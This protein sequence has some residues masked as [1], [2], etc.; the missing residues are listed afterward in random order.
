MR[1]LA[2][3][4]L[5][6]PPPA[7]EG[8]WPGIDHAWALPSAG[9]WFEW[10]TG[11]RLLTDSLLGDADELLAARR[12]AVAE[13]R[14]EADWAKRRAD[15]RGKFAQIFGRSS[16]QGAA[17]RAQHSPLNPK[18]TKRT[19]HPELNATVE[20]L[21]FESRPGFFVT[22]GLWLPAEDAPGKDP[23]TGKR[24]GILFAS[25]HSCQAWRRLDE[26]DYFDYHFLLLQLVRKGFV[27]L[28]YDPPGQGERLFYLN[29]TCP[30]EGPRSACNRR[31]L[32]GGCAWDINT[33]MDLPWG[34]SSTNEHSYL[35][36][37][38][39]LNNVTAA[40]IW[41]W[42]GTRALDL[43]MSRPE[44][45]KERVGM[46][47]CSGGGTQTAYLSSVDERIQAASVA[48]YSSAFEVDFA[49]GGSGADAE[50][51]WPGGLAAKLNKADLSV[52]RSPQATQLLLTTLD[53]CF[54]MA[55]GR[56]CFED[57]K[58]AFGST[59][60]LTKAE[61]EG[62]HGMQ[63]GTRQALYGFMQKHLQKLGPDE[64]NTTEDFGI[65]PFTM[66]QVIATPTGSVVDDLGSLTVANLSAS[67]TAASVARLQER[68]KQQGAFLS[69]VGPSAARLSGFKRLPVI[70]RGGAIRTADGL[71]EATL[72]GEITGSTAG[73]DAGLWVQ[74]WFVHSE[75]TCGAVLTL[76]CA[77]QQQGSAARPLPVV[78][79]TA[80]SAS[81][82]AP[83]QPSDLS[84]TLTSRLSS[85]GFCVAIANL[86]GFGEVG[87][88]FGPADRYEPPPKMTA[89]RGS[90]APP[91]TQPKE[92][93]PAALAGEQ[94]SGLASFTGRSIVG[95]QAGELAR[96]IDFLLLQPGVSRL[97]ALAAADH[98]DAAA[99]HLAAIGLTPGAKTTPAPA[100]I[101]L[102]AVTSYASIG[103]AQFYQAPIYRT[104]VGAL[105]EYDLPDLAA[106]AVCH[107]KHFGSLL[108]VGPRSP[109]LAP[110]DSP[111]AEEEYSL[112]RA[113][114]ASLE[115]VAG[116]RSP[117]DAAETIE[118]FLRRRGRRIKTDESSTVD[119]N[120]VELSHV[121]ITV[122]TGALLRIEQR[123]AKGYDDRPTLSFPY[124]SAAPVVAFTVSRPG[125]QRILLHT[126]NLTLHL[127]ESKLTS[128][129]ELSPAAL[130]VDFTASDGEPARTWRFGDADDGNLRGT[131]HSLDCYVSSD[132][133]AAATCLAPGLLERGLLS[134]SGPVLWEDTH[135][136][137]YDS[138]D[139]DS[140]W[141][142]DVSAVQAAG[143]S[144]R[145]FY[146]LAHGR[147]YTEAL[148]DY[149]LVGGA[150]LLPPTTAMGVWW[151]RY[152][153]YT[154]DSF[155]E[156]VLDGYRDHALPL[157]QVVMDVDWRECSGD[158]CHRAV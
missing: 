7:A 83:T 51:Q 118:T 144:Y 84:K 24:A 140:A 53:G 150:P 141:I 31:S 58:P 37:Q 79:L 39:L 129:G 47:G 96:V 61:A 81:A 77:K 145:D 109:M 114:G 95:R 138:E 121:R 131:R 117:S 130:S 151:S 12:A 75:G 156:Q 110:L 126:A 42:D 139:I 120:T 44:V 133:E 122:L 76:R 56:M 97:A 28:A 16:A 143:A 125:P 92:Q 115:I 57:A 100:L 46:T 22:A 108:V 113:C 26:P 8:Q 23:V 149:I 36:W 30:V 10:S 128:S 127:D 19:V 33:G 124:R 72:L 43:L 1:L 104:V 73:F 25:G 67:W 38:L 137:R 136:G 70:D 54:P 94:P 45:A 85:A 82:A 32:I 2:L 135:R 102:D 91:P 66:P 146:L 132:A 15:V 71:P 87:P 11:P 60:N 4:L 111:A 147:R 155:T 152:N 49:W 158:L 34:G 112:A 40:S 119:G 98:S 27:V 103:Q 101:V 105:K 3:A 48:C 63:N 134:R 142:S 21:Y 157:D 6:C 65:T 55:G 20:M 35:G 68:R 29:G 41:V 123:G 74:K 64:L 9:K 78:L 62:P 50:Q 52:A 90:H 154:K 89:D 14:T 148:A 17:E 99:L 86:C 153:N 116:A 107:K 59:G 93:R 18:I 13:L 80:D 88:G 106:A 5:A 69:A